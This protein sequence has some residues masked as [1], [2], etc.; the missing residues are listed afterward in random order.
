MFG[1]RHCVHCQE[2]VIGRKSVCDKCKAILKKDGVLRF[3]RKNP[4]RWTEIQTLSQNRYRIRIR[5]RVFL[6]KLY[7]TFGN[8]GVD[9]FYNLIDEQF[10]EALKW[11]DES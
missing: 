3:K 4:L 7:N 6:V 11:S 9:Y 5:F 2:V 1:V 8:E 10:L